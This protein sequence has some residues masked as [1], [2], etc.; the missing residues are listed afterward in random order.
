[1]IQRRASCGVED[2]TTYAWTCDGER[3][4]APTGKADQV[5]QLGRGL[6]PAT[7][8]LGSPIDPKERPR[9]R[10]VRAG[11]FDT[12]ARGPSPTRRTI[13]SCVNEAALPPNEAPTD[14]RRWRADGG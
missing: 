5:R 1:M 7:A 10:A 14:V 13:R 11:R 8:R 3:V 9:T 6:G 4:G 2:R 12:M